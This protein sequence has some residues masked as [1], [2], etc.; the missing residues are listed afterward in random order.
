MRNPHVEKRLAVA[1]RILDAYPTGASPEAFAVAGS[2]G[3]GLADRFSDLEIDCYWDHAPGDSERLAPVSALGADLTTLWPY[4]EAD[5]EFSE[6]YVLDGL[7]VTIS[8]FTCAS[9]DAMIADMH[10][11][12]SIADATQY[13]FAALTR[14][15]VLSGGDTVE[16]WRKRIESMPD[17]VVAWTVENALAPDSLPGWN[18]RTALVERRDVIAVRGLLASIGRAVFHAVLAA[19]RLYRPHRIAKWQHSLL[20]ECA[21]L[22]ERFD[23]DLD[24]LCNTDLSVALVHAE[25]LVLNTLALAEGVLGG[26]LP[27]VRAGLETQRN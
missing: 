4:D 27:G 17:S 24:G 15:R 19:N 22:P 8:N 20:D 6:D 16:A 13:R 2:V 1:W 3:A 26:E 7:D 14:S 23:E 10:D 11:Q 21:L 25:R 12:G 5:Q 18:A 9:V